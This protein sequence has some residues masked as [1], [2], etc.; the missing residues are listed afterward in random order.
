[1][2]KVDYM[3]HFLEWDAAGDRPRR[4]AQDTGVAT[5]ICLFGAHLRIDERSLSE[6]Y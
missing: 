1:V 3:W 5:F 2:V 4:S 6:Y